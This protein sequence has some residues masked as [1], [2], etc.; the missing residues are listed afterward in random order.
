MASITSLTLPVRGRALRLVHPQHRGHEQHQQGATAVE[1]GGWVPP[2]AEIGTGQGRHDV[3]EVA[4]FHRVQQPDGGG[5]DVYQEFQQD[6][7]VPEQ[8]PRGAQLLDNPGEQ[9]AA[10]LDA[11]GLRDGE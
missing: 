3:C 5:R 8:A 6:P 10:I 9:R 1:Y 7:I 4:E 11:F 2:L